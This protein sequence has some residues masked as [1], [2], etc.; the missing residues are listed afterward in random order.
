[1]QHFAPFLV[2][3]TITLGAFLMV[4]G[5]RYMENKEN[6]ALIEKGMEPKRKRSRNPSAT[7]KNA[8]L[9]IGA[10][11][12]LLLAIMITSFFNMSEDHAIGIFF[13]LIAIFGGLGM[14]AA[15]MYDQRNPQ[16]Q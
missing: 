8:L 6:M 3:I 4:F 10:G 14:L 7:L 9:F 1:M 2:P 15:Y 11:L 13:A 16:D 12:G 5:L